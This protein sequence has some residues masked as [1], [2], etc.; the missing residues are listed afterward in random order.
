MADYVVGDIQGCYRGLTRLLEY[1][2]FDPSHDTLIAVGDLIGRGPHALETLQYLYSLQGSF[3]TVL[4]NHDLH[5]LAVYSG[6]RKNK[7]NDKYDKLL[8][9]SDVDKYVHW[10]RH[11]PLALTLDE[12]TLVCH[13]GLYPQWSIA[14]AQALS[15]EVSANL[16]TDNW[17]SVLKKM[18]GDEPNR[19]DENLSGSKRWRFII[20][21]FTRMRYMLDS[22]TLEFN[23]K[24]SPEKTPT[25]FRP[26]FSVKNTNL[27]PNDKVL[28]GHWA[29]LAGNTNTDKFI[30]LDTGYIWQQQLTLWK[31][32][33]GE[34]YSVAYQD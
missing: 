28:F 19:W 30:A 13:A 12:N 27:K 20:N 5:F 11:Q 16:Q 31:R 15:D 22:H 34:K 29:T 33:N 18:Y 14:Q 24:D 1:V 10:L 23:C 32:Q 21:A 25:R 9:S 2:K 7:A 17:Q 6:I 4:G 26:W 3:S 8:A